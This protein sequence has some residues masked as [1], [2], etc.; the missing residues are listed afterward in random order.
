MR[1]I[2]FLFLCLCWVTQFSYA[3]Q[4]QLLGSI[5][6]DTINSLFGTQIVP[7]GDQNNDGN[8][9][10]LIWDYRATARLYLG[11]NSV[12]FNPTLKFEG[13][14]QPVGLPGLVNADGYLDLIV[15][16]SSGGPYRAKLFYGGPSIDTVVD[17]S[18]GVDSL[19][20]FHLFMLV[21]PD[22]N[23]N[24]TDELITQ[25]HVTTAKNLVFYE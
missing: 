10:I 6:S 12:D 5:P 15:E 8:S 2:L 18:F 20:G 13:I 9:D 17:F 24:G 1:L 16:G 7:M 21:S 25:E 11:G 3:Q 19:T 23:Q 22:V 4:P 14:L